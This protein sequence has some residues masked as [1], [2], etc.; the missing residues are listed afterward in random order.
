MLN[1]SERE[2]SV[3]NFRHAHATPTIDGVVQFNFDFTCPKAAHRTSAAQRRQRQ[4]QLQQQRQQHKQKQLVSSVETFSLL[5]MG[6]GGGGDITVCMC[7]CVCISF[8]I[9]IAPP[10]PACK[11]SKIRWKIEKLLKTNF[12]LD[13]SWRIFIP[14]QRV[15]WFFGSSLQ[16]TLYVCIYIL[17]LHQQSSRFMSKRLSV[18]LSVHLSVRLSVCCNAN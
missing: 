8:Q 3:I 7:V 10:L 9:L 6:G 14:W 12:T 16:C 17:N 5:S 1:C 4:R 18:R 11:K 2:R 13:I 15:Y